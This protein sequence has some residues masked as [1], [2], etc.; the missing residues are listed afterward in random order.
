MIR[1]ELVVDKMKKGKY[2]LLMIAHAVRWHFSPAIPYR[3]T[4]AIT[5]LE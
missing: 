3:H 1:K 5:A 4:K 2:K